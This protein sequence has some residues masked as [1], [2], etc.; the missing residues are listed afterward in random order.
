MFSSYSA[1]AKR[2]GQK[3]GGGHCNISRP[4]P[5]ARREL[6][7]EKGRHLSDL[8]NLTTVV[9]NLS[10]CIILFTPKN[11][12]FCDAAFARE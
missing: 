1:K 4:G 3:D 5:S 6:I 10:L 2:D 7:N 12:G 8:G 11:V 9:G